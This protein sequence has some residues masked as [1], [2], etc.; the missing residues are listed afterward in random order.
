[1][2]DN[3]AY[4]NWSQWRETGALLLRELSSDIL[5]DDDRA[6]QMWQKVNEMQRGCK[7][8]EDRAR[9]PAASLSALEAW[10]RSWAVSKQALVF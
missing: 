2:P 4:E 7:F 3:T 6:R 9:L 1:M 8:H 10:L 5:R